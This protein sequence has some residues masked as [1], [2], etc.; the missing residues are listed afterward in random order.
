MSCK[1]SVIKMFLQK[2]WTSFWCSDLV[3]IYEKRTTKH[4]VVALIK[5][6]NKQDIPDDKL[7]IQQD[8]RDTYIVKT[9]YLRTAWKRS[10]PPF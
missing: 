5:Q 1:S 7:C 9:V 3:N 10:V 6:Q 8:A 4:N 2:G